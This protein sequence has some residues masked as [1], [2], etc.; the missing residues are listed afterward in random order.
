MNSART[1]IAVGVTV[2]AF[3]SVVGADDRRGRD[4]DDNKVVAEAVVVHFG[5][6]QPQTPDPAP[7]GAAVTHFLMPNDIT[8]KKGQAVN[9]VVNGGG[10][11]IAIHEVSK[12]STR[13]DIARDLRDG[14]TAE[15]AD[16]IADRRA[17]AAV[18][19]GAAVTAV[20]I[21]GTLVNVTGT[22]NLDY[23]IT[24]GK[25]DLVIQTG[26][27]VNIP[28]TPTTPAIVRNN[29]RVD[30]IQ[31]SHR[32]LG[33]SGASVNDTNNPAAIAGNRAGAF[34]TGSANP[35]TAGN[36]INVTFLKTGRYLVICMNRAHSLND[37]MFGFVN[38][39]DD[40]DDQ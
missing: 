18:C 28:A 19:N 1:S 27:N 17:R 15:N 3:A 5:Q 31:H 32:L 11:G 40:D 30:D 34:L 14:N 22:Q 16:P 38:V 24:D 35:A 10:H 12:K 2:L 39:V 21:D 6:P 23:A 9:F 36:R 13:D 33:T 37:H 25:D 4:N 20:M 7:V 8:I 26:F 29:P